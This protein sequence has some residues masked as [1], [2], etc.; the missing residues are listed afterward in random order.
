MRFTRFDC[1]IST[2]RSLSG[3]QE[4]YNVFN[5]LGHPGCAAIALA[6]AP[7]NGVSAQVACSLALEHYVEAVTAFFEARETPLAADLDAQTELNL[8]LL[9]SAFRDAKED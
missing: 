3:R 5:P 9:E 4:A 7:R 1:H 6:S 2:G 8:E